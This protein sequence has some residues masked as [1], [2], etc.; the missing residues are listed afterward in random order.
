MGV[1][2]LD[3]EHLGLKNRYFFQ[4]DL[5]YQIDD[6]ATL[7]RS[8]LSAVSEGISQVTGKVLLKLVDT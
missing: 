7:T 3:T 8:S 4:I 1:L 5:Q 6:R 2:R